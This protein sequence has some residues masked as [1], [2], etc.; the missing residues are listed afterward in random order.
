MRKIRILAFVPFVIGAVI[1][2]VAFINCK[3]GAK[4]SHSDNLKFDGKG[5]ALVELFTS[6]GCSSCPPA[7]E[8]VARVQKEV[9]DKPVYI[10]AYHVDYWNRLGWKD[11]F[12]SADYS[13]RQNEYARWLNLSQVYTPQIVVNGKTEF[14]GSQE[15]RLRSTIKSGLQGSD[16]VQ[17]NLSVTLSTNNTASVQY[18][19]EGNTGSAPNVISLALVQKQ[20]VV[21][22]ERGENGGRTLAHAQIVRNLQTMPLNKNNGSATIALPAGVE[23]RGW[24]VIGFVQNTSNGAVLAASKS[25]FKITADVGQ[26]DK[27]IQ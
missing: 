7:D 10:L 6:E 25:L 18:K 27:N 4:T 19:V 23:A 9:G 14:V 22:V 12:S 21:K 20:A 3:S 2:S 17:L 11:V 8:L 13:K 15:E 26:Q 5:F 16:S 24:E 1:V